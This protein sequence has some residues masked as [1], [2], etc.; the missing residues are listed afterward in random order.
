MR[1]TT[2]LKIDK[3]VN[4]VDYRILMQT[5]YEE[6]KKWFEA[7]GVDK[8]LM[9]NAGLQPNQLE[10]RSKYL[11][12]PRNYTVRTEHE[13]LGKQETT[14]L[15]DFKYPDDVKSL[16]DKPT[17]II[18][19]LE[20]IKGDRELFNF[21]RLALEETNLLGLVYSKNAIDVDDGSDVSTA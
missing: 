10:M 16:K 18:K 2:I 6:L 19:R 15:I 9:S 12:L 20:F 3:S 1:W 8:F 13:E 21:I 14:L 11:E 17:T 7:E 5:F 4:N